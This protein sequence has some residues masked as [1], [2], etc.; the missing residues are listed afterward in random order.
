MAQD[1]MRAMTVST[2]GMKAQGLRLRVISENLANADSV[3]QGPGQEP[4]RRKVV[5]FRNEL[6]R[7]DN[8]HKVSVSRV[9]TDPSKFQTKYDPTHPYADQDGYIMAP[10]VS[11]LIETMDMREAQRSYEANLNVIETS[12]SMLTRTIDL[13]R[14]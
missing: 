8:M 1:L 13:L 10:N 5:M 3:A 9:T 6:D 11:A 7:A 14:S 2:S 4:Y 12:M